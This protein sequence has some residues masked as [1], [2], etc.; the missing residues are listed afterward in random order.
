MP[1]GLGGADRVHGSFLLKGK[2]ALH[3]FSLSRGGLS[4]GVTIGL[5]HSFLSLIRDTMNYLCRI[6]LLLIGMFLAASG[7]SLITAVSLGT[8]P[9]STVPLVLSVLS[10][11]T[12][13][14]T[15]FAVNCF[16]I[17]MQWVLL[18]EHFHWQTLLQIPA[19]FVFSAF[20][21][22]T[23]RLWLPLAPDFYLGRLGMSLFGNVL[24]ASGI[25]LQLHSR[26]IVQPGE[27]L[28]LAASVFF[29]KNFGTMKIVNDWTLVAI[30]AVIGLL[31]TRSVVGI[32]EGTL[33]SAFLIGFIVK[34]L[35]RFFPMKKTKGRETSGAAS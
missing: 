14:E 5:L 31:F 25:V 1:A 32:R 28:V 6:A 18:R 23:M 20:I 13:G 2:I 16:F 17:F 24:L 19:V 12:F 30:A 8:T 26:T 33:I 27:G 22:L 34:V 3:D 15:T 29:R 4:P 10:G 9:I 21:D 7:I 35:L 11:F